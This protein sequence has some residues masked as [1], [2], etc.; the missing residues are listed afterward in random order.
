MEASWRDIA[1]EERRSERLGER[2]GVSRA[3]GFQ[4]LLCT[5]WNERLGERLQRLRFNLC[6]EYV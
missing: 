6:H 1:A 2:A 3:W 4:G 5:A